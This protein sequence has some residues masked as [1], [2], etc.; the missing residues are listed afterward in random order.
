MKV[1]VTGGAGFIGS[2]IADTFIQAGHQV[3]IVDN[4]RTGKEANLNPRAKFYRVDIR[5]RDALEMVFQ[6]EKPDI[7]SHQAALANVRESV[8]HPAEYAEVNVVGSI[9]LLELAHKY[10]VKKFIYA[11][12][13]GA[14]YG[15]PQKL[16]V[17]EDHPVNPLDPYGA[18]KHAFEHYLFLYHANFKL[19]YTVLRYPNV[20]GPRQDPYGEA[21]VIAIFTVKLL[22]GEQPIINGDGLQTRDFVYVGDIAHANLLASGR[23]D[24]EIVNIGWGKG[25]DINTIFKTLRDITHSHAEEIHGPAKIGEVRY[26]YLDASRAGRLLGWE[27]S[28]TL[29]EGLKETVEYFRK[30]M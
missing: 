30:S 11:S 28:I 6:L 14:C 4:L 25:T 19:P 27:P 22:K 2:H 17:T 10:S 18:S 9:Q 23:A 29:D 12:T 16:P 24:G 26:I 13:G 3:V 5:N 8:E 21:G 7:I 1:L 20:F 15:E